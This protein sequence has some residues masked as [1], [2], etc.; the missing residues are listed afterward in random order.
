M[1][2]RYAGRGLTFLFEMIGLLVI[3][4]MA[5]VL[6]LMLRLQQG[7]VQ[8]DFL[9]ERVETAFARYQN[10]FVFDI[11]GTQ[12]NWG[13]PADPFVLDMQDL[14]ITRSD[15]TPVAVVAKAR[16]VL[17][18]RGLLLGRIVPKEFY[19]SRPALRVVRNLDGGISLNVGS[20]DLPTDAAVEKAWEDTTIKPA[21]DSTEGAARGRAARQEFIASLVRQMENPSW[22]GMLGGLQRIIID[23]AA[24]AYEDRVL[25]IFW[26]AE[27]AKIVVAREAAGIVADT[28]F[29]GEFSGRPEDAR[30]PIIRLRATRV[31][32]QT[33]TGV[34]VF[35]ANVVP[36]HL[37][38]ESERLAFLQGFDVPLKGQISLTLDADLRASDAAFAVAGGAGTLNGFDLYPVPVAVTSLGARGRYHVPSGLGEVTAA[39]I[40]LG[41]AKATLTAQITAAETTSAIP[42]RRVEVQGVL[43]G[44]PLDSLATYWPKKL[45]TDAQHWVT[46]HLSQGVAERATLDIAMLLA[47]DGTRQ[48][49][50]LGGEIDFRDI[51]VDYFPPLTKV[52]GVTGKATYDADSFNLAIGA[53]K[54]DDIQITG[55]RIEISD[56]SQASTVGQH[57]S[58]DIT[59]DMNGPLQTALRVIDSPPL[60]YP[61]ELG[62]ALDNVA[63]Q[64]ATTVTFAFPLHKALDISEVIV[65]ASS[66]ITDAR[67]PNVALGRDLTGGPFELTLAQGQLRVAG[68]GRLDDSGIKLDWSRNFTDSQKPAMDLQAQLTAPAAVLHEFGLPKMVQLS[69]FLPAKIGLTERQDGT[70]TLLLD[71]DLASLGVDAPS[72]GV[73]KPEG[74]AGTLALELEMTNDRPTSLRRVAINAEGIRAEGQLDFAPAGETRLVR[75]NLTRLQ[76]GE[77]DLKQ[78]TIGMPVRAGDAYTAVLRGAVLDASPLFTNDETPNS[79]E[80][81]AVTTPP[82][83]LDIAVDKLLTGKARSLEAVDLKLA[84]NTHHRLEQ[85]D[86]T[87]TAGGKPLRVQYLPASPVGKSLRVE[88]G[89]AG[90]A[91]HALGITSAIQGGQLTLD[92]QP[93]VKA[94][95]PILTARDLTGTLVIS[96]FETR[97]APVLAKLL[98]ALSL[99][100]LRDLLTN[101]GLSFKKA[102]ARFTLTDRGQPG[103]FEN[104]RLIRI[105]DGQTSGSSMGLTFEGAIDLWRH[106]YDL[107]GTIVPVSDLN[108]LLEKIPLLGDVLTAGGEGIFAATY[109]ISGPQKDPEVSVNPLSVLAPGVLRKIFFED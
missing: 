109:K 31:R 93:V 42:A 30:Q 96:D 62:L 87:A 60:Q 100:G 101:K 55:A 51:T 38:G 57:A 22:D 75:A 105:A 24:V 10:G 97:D 56:L 45:A 95:D 76:L 27:H 79:N 7:P 98:N 94:A 74:V 44:M 1:I 26:R 15:T 9:T 83:A 37:S 21:D 28:V 8:L 4:L 54:L 2:R 5:A 23:D 46:T 14:R 6:A 58:I 85:L 77:N 12:L 72:F 86:L 65:T 20:G 33:D 49:E 63:G 64:A 82:L 90:A 104:Q 80:A 50:T 34:T 36:G 78:V 41:V 25:N 103:S 89:N 66:K 106:I 61:S 71:A 17:S 40:D 99:S 53:G 108:T 91:L 29:Q 16:V 47:D 84:R 3:I 43:T 70:A 73:T 52:T 32:G 11:Q 88:A 68:E 35:F 67:L 107:N 18:K 69:G 13:S 59:V 92:A 39:E 19:L 81:A 102:R 48:I